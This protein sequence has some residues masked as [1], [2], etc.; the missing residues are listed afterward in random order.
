MRR[1]GKR[2]A[3]LDAAQRSKAGRLEGAESGRCSFGCG[4]FHVRKPPP[5]P[6]PAKADR[7]R[8]PRGSVKAAVQLVLGGNLTVARAALT[9]GANPESVEA[10]AWAAAKQLV[11]DR[12]SE[13]CLNCG[14]AGTDVHHRVRRGMGGT[15]DPV[16]AFGLANLALLCRPCHA[17]AHKTDDPEMAA[18]GYRLETTA[19]P[20]AEPLML[21]SEFG[22][23]APVWLKPD[24]GYATERP[25]RADAA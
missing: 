23:G 16:I 4:G 22:S 15:A 13:T 9:Y 21:F 2:Y 8:S 14:H 17:L 12:D 3:S 20:A 19:D 10:A 18:K 24:R 7:P 5:A 25:P 6:G 11:R 1:C